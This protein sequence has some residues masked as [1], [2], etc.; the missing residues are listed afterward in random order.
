MFNNKSHVPLNPPIFAVARTAQV[1]TF[2]I[3]CQ[4]NISSI[5]VFKQSAPYPICCQASPIRKVYA[6]KSEYDS[7]CYPMLTSD[8]M[9]LIIFKLVSHIM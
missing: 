7:K 9:L 6:N 4:I 8:G 3:L 2:Y 5:L 1:N